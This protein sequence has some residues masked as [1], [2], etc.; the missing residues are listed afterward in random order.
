MRFPESI[1]T[2]DLEAS[3][4]CDPQAVLERVQRGELTLEQAAWTFGVCFQGEPTDPGFAVDAAATE[5]RRQEIRM[6]AAPPG[7]A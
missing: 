4:A 7:G 1:L 5:L 2:D 3:L 6:A